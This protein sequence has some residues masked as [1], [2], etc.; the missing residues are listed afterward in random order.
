MAMAD[1]TR[2]GEEGKLEAQKARRRERER[3]RYSQNKEAIRNR[4]QS[5]RQKN[6]DSEFHKEQ[7]RAHDKE[8]RKRHASQ[9]SAYAR[10]YYAKHQEFL[11]GQHARR[12]LKNRAAIIARHVRN[13][14]KRRLED[15]CF[16]LVGR[17]RARVR[18]ALS[19]S[20][21]PRK[22]STLTLIGCTAVELK[23]YIES[24]FS[25]GMSWGNRRLW[26]VDHIIPISKFDLS[27][28]IQQAAA[29][30][31][32]N[33]QP[34]W[35]ADNLR[36]GDKV[37]G[38]HLFGFAYAVRIVDAISTKPKRRQSHGRKSGHNQP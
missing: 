17:V 13:Q 16:A 9:L 27:D 28:P 37:S 3:I 6:R 1:S 5:F 15:E 35:A 36:K 33:L 19:R 34:L 4:Q 8:Y 14:A 30:H 24:R 22:Q 32:T 12:Y 20:G 26:H 21:I 31:Y 18:E 11:K 2:P 29:F 23:A 7:R 25:P 38:Q 10:A